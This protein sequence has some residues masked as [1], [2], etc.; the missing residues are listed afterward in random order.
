M[1]GCWPSPGHGPYHPDNTARR[2]NQIKRYLNGGAHLVIAANMT[3]GYLTDTDS[4]TWQNT[5]SLA[6]KANLFKS[7][8]SL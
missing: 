5:I 1:V 4:L 3:K 7:L 6:E 2:A 8:R